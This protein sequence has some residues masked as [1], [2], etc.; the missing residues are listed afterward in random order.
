MGV[1]ILGGV[2]VAFVPWDSRFYRTGSGAVLRQFWASATY[3][4]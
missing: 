2:R 3:P 4:N 1:A